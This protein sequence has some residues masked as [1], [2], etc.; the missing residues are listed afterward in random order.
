MKVNDLKKMYEK[1]E[2]T[3]EMDAR[4]MDN[5]GKKRR[6]SKI[7]YLKIASVAAVFAIMV[8][9][10]QVPSVNAAV[11]RFIEG[12]TNR[13]TVENQV[14]E[15]NGEYIVL[16]EDA[17]RTDKKFNTLADV[18]KELGISILKSEDAY[19]K[20]KN[21]ISY[22]PHISDDGNLYG[23]MLMDEFYSI[24]D[25]KNVSTRTYPEYQNVNGISFE[26]G[27]KYNGPIAMQ[28]NIRARTQNT[29]N[30][31]TGDL[32]YSE[33]GEIKYHGEDVDVSDH[34]NAEIYKIKKLDVKAVITVNKTDG[35]A[36]WEDN[37]KEGKIT[38]AV[39]VFDGI[40]YAYYGMVSPDTM[41]AFLETL[42]Y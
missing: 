38:D 24:G 23:V 33:D 14:V 26:S 7:S 39:F 28:I 2:T 13:I 40:E 1:I 37:N 3:E 30:S 10:Y 8:G 15:M 18:E 12:F 9:V 22:N 35:P 11:N 27:K 25:L 20:D 41:K 21:L 5:L 4:I 42:G 32:I 34:E 17:F 19:E 31:E 6:K 29:D 36:E 16:N